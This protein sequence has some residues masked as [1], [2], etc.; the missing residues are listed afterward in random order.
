MKEKLVYLTVQISHEVK[1]DLKVA[2]AMS[3]EDLGKMTEILIS[4]ALAARKNGGK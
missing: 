4:E 1:R 3:G 2:A